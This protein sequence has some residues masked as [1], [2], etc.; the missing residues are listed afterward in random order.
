SRS[1]LFGIGK[2]VPSP[3][4][5]A[6]AAARSSTS[7]RRKWRSTESARRGARHETGRDGAATEHAVAEG[8]DAEGQEQRGQALRQR[9]P[10]ERIEVREEDEEHRNSPHEPTADRHV[11]P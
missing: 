9:V 4:T 8:P 3:A 2:D 1:K 5:W 11:E 7:A 10:Q 6:V